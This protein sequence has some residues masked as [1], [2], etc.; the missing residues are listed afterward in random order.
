MMAAPS[1]GGWRAWLV[2]LLVSAAVA[3]ALVAPLAERGNPSGHDI[4]FH[5]S[6]WL[7]VAGQWRQGIL[8]PRWAEWANGGFGE[9]RFVFYPPL[10]WALGAALGLAV[11]W[12][13][14]AAAFIFLAQTMAGLCMFA[15]ARRTL[16][17]G[18]ALFAAAAYAAN[19]YAQVVIYLRADFAEL[20]A[21]SFFPLLLLFAGDLVDAEG[22]VR[23]R[24]AVFAAAFA[25]IWLANAPAGVLA[26][27]SAA[28]LFAWEAAARR[29]WRPLACGGAGLALG[30]GLCAFYLLPAGYEQRWVNIAQALE[31]GLR[32]TENFLYAEIADPE[33]NLF[34]WIVSTAAVGM[35]ALAAVA[36][37]AAHRRDETAEHQR[38]RQR[39]VL[40]GAAAAL[41]MF[42]WTAPLW[43]LLPKLRYLQFPWRWMLVLAVALAWLAA[44]ALAQRR[45]AW[46]GAVG[47][48]VLFAVTGTFAVRHAWWD[49]EDIPVLRAAIASGAGYEGTDEYD[50]LGDDHTDLPRRAPPVQLLPAEEGGAAIA[51]AE[52][53]IERWTAEEKLVRVSSRAPARAALRLLNYPA[54]RVEVNGARVQPQRAEDTQQMILPLGAGESRIAV[55][56]TRTPDRT[57]G[58]WL[59]LAS[60]LCAAA[61]SGWPQRG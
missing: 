32:P 54:W 20:L 50:P 22:T 57:L 10:A 29:S 1:Q 2:A 61:L 24:I 46:L 16:P 3:A 42:R 56:F 15:L 51:P 49:W 12:K 18:A 25:A 60:A 39:L 44:A 34:N 31:T 8:Y 41:L 53:R 5:A 58:I 43:R 36:V 13:A 47:I 7:D 26:S 30:F 9:P 27:Y 21:I 11:G 55:R 52:V 33:H 4:Q 6:N 28:L 35:I 45:G 17:P 19:P 37:P 38:T 14:A 59:T 48:L 23:R 40:L